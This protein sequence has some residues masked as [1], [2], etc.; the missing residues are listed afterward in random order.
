M[1]FAV[2]VTAWLSRLTR[3]AARTT[4]LVVGLMRLLFG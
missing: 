1:R 3:L 2:W 4:R